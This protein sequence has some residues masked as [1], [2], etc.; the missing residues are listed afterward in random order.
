[1][2]RGEERRGEERRGEERRGEERGGGC[3]KRTNLNTRRDRCR[4]L[5]T[6]GKKDE[7]KERSC[8]ERKKKKV[9]KQEVMGRG[10]VP[11]IQ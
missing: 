5:E 8:K 7:M 11:W 3:R 2:R 6:K 9:I 4:H 1:M 10:R